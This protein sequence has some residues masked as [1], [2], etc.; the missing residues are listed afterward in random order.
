MYP[1]KTLEE[2]LQRVRDAKHFEIVYRRRYGLDLWKDPIRCRG[3]LKLSPDE[4]DDI[5]RSLRKENCYKDEP[6]LDP[7]NP[8]RKFFFR[9]PYK[10]GQTL[11]IELFIKLSS[12]RHGL[13]M[14]DSFHESHIP[15]SVRLEMIDDI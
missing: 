10:N 11:Q 12:P 13:I 6:S 3:R 8:A 14:V 2:I 9:Y 4:T 7:K 5:I 15:N 1:A